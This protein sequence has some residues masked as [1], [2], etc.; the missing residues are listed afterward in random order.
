MEA[1]PSCKQTKSNF[2]SSSLSSSPVHSRSTPEYLSNDEPLSPPAQSTKGDEQKN[3]EDDDHFHHSP[4]KM[5]RK[6]R[7]NGKLI[8][9]KQKEDELNIKHYSHPIFPADHLKDSPITRSS[10]L[11]QCEKCSCKDKSSNSLTS[12]TFKS[13]TNRIEFDDRKV[14]CDLIWIEENVETNANRKK[15]KYVR[16]NLPPSK[17]MSLS[18]ILN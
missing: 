11:L 4:N 17:K 1:E 10:S 7:R 16:K 12:V 18:F 9:N 3:D 8:K 14:E 13:L 6:I 15:R 2:A 5:L